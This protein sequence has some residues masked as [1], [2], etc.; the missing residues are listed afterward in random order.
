[1][2][3]ILVDAVMFGL[4]TKSKVR[5]ADVG[6]SHCPQDVCKSICRRV[7]TVTSAKPRYKIRN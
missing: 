7:V 1:M 2:L 5:I 3:F 6:D 4:I